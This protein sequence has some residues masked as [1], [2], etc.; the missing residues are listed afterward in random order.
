MGLAV[1]GVEIDD[2][3]TTAKT[4][5]EFPALWQRLVEGGSGDAASRPEAMRAS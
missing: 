2:I 1:P 5:P 4:M 3:G